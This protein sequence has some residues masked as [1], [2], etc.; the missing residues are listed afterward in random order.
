MKSIYSYSKIITMEYELDRGYIFMTHQWEWKLKDEI[1]DTELCAKCGTCVVVC[2][3]DLLDFENHPKLIEECLRKGNGM[4][5]DICPR[6]SSG[7]YQIKIRESFKK[8]F[9]MGKEM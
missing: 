9:F 2:P 3:N 8:E 7:G 1:V 5:Y 6:V 4:C